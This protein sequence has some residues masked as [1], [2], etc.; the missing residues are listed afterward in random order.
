M[1]LFRIFILVLLSPLL[2]TATVLY[3]PVLLVG[4][5]I[6]ML[7]VL[8]TRGRISGTAYEPLQ[9]RLFYHLRGTRPDPVALELSR[10][11]PATSWGFTPVVMTPFVW[12]C[13]LFPGLLRYPPPQPSRWE[14]RRNLCCRSTSALWMRPCSTAF[15]RSNRS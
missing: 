1:S 5:V 4:V 8:G 12:I 10:H 15:S 11:L 9:M 14:P 7:R 13:K 6:C 3:V 2:V